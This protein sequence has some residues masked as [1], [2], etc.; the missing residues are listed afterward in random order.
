MTL[1]LKQF[2]KNKI[3]FMSIMTFLG[4][5]LGVYYREF[6]RALLGDI[7]LDKYTIITKTIGLNHGHFF[8]LGLIFPII[9][10]FLL[11]LFKSDIGEKKLRSLKKAFLIYI[12]G[13][14]LTLSLMVIKGSSYVWV[15]SIEKSLLNIDSKIILGESIFRPIA[16]TIAHV[17]LAVGVVWYMTGIL[18][19]KLK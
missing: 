11:N 6:T 4:L 1:Q 12:I 15:Y 10:I 3:I 17:S 5:A 18:R 16:Y 8:I 13:S 2:F 19:I 9:F 14:L 7:S